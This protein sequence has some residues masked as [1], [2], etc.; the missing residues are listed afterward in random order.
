MEVVS[1]AKSKT[2]FNSGG[3]KKRS[4]IIQNIVN[5]VGYGMD[6]L[7][8]NTYMTTPMNNRDLN[9]VKD[10]FNKSL[11]RLMTSNYDN[12]GDS[13]LSKLFTSTLDKRDDNLTSLIDIFEDQKANRCA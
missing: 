3:D 13:N 2:P 12:N 4:K 10:D 8:K 1:L 11:D 6:T 9:N 5:N 7:Y